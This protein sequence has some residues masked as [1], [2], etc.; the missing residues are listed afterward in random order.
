MLKTLI[1]FLL[2]AL[3]A[4]GNGAFA[5]SAAV[6]KQFAQKSREDTL[7]Q[8]GGAASAP[9]GYDITSGGPD[10][11]F[12]VIHQTEISHEWCDMVMKNRPFLA[13]LPSMGFTELVCTY[14]NGN[15]RFVFDLLVQEQPAQTQTQSQPT[16]T[17]R[18]TPQDMDLANKAIDL[19]TRIIHDLSASN[20]DRGANMSERR[21][22]LQRILPQMNEVKDINKQL[23]S[24]NSTVS[25]QVLV[26]E[27]PTETVREWV[28]LLTERTKL[29][30][31]A[32]LE[33]DAISR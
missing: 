9:I 25:P 7:K 31:E 29:M 20:A 12:F 27:C 13:G 4:A 22:V 11:T 6:R 23:G 28:R 10:E 26:G 17:C 15:A 33:I 16:N 3:P 21:K 14:G 32:M 8:W 30:D 5:Q 2:L 19:T 1:G 24:L 18:I